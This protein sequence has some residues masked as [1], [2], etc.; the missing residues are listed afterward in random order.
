MNGRHALGR[1]GEC[2]DGGNGDAAV[3]DICTAISST[4]ADIVRIAPLARRSLGPLATNCLRQSV[5]QL[6]Q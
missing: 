3:Q 6:R 4:L 2:P 5:I 1:M